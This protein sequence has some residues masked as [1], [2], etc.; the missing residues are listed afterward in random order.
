M[1]ILFLLIKLLLIIYVGLGIL[2]YIFQ[3]NLLYYPA[4]KI[5]YP[6]KRMAFQNEN[7]N[8]N[9]IVL[10]EGKDNAIFYFGGNGES[11][12]YNAEIFAKIFPEFTLYLVDYRGYGWSN[13]EPTEQG[14]YSD[15]LVLYDS[16]K[17]QYKNI[18][19]MGR[20]LGS[21]VAT[22]LA[23]KR[24]IEKMVLIT[25]YDSIRNVAQ[26]MYPVY[27][28]RLILKDQYD[29]L[30]NLEKKSANKVL[31][32]MAEDDSLIPN[33][34]SYTLA[35]NIPKEIL[36]VEVIKGAGHNS[37]SSFDRYYEI[38]GRYLGGQ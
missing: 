38:L 30:Q 21:G 10:N 25:P 31:I 8:I 13:G 34:H 27:P 15:A 16:L 14:L 37:I 35:K 24:D 5:D 18:N 28:M 19:L 11:V 36:H 22:Y 17:E 23:S 29:S 33:K 1:K 20:S 7:Q 4:Q 12:V 3:R 26:E 2:L 6:Y 32:V 9:T